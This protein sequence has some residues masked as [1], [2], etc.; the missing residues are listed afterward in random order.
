MAEENKPTLPSAT[1]PTEISTEE[2]SVTDDGAGVGSIFTPEALVMFAIAG[3][4]DLIGLIPLVNIVS[5]IVAG[6]TISAWMIGT[7][8]KGWPRFII[9]FILELLPGISTITPTISI[10]CMTLNVKLPASWVGCIY[11]IMSGGDG[12]KKGVARVVAK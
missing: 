9:A 4:F 6:I 2:E 1:A 12:T 7:G 11:C 3:V 10:I 5:S 8:R